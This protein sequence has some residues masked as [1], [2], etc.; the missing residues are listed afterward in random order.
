MIANW[1]LN[2]KIIFRSPGKT[3]FG[4]H[5]GCWVC[6]LSRGRCY[7][8]IFVLVLH[9]AAQMVPTH[10]RNENESKT[11]QNMRRIPHVHGVWIKCG[12]YIPSDPMYMG[13][14]APK[15][16]FFWLILVPSMCEHH[17]GCEVETFILNTPPY[18]VYW[19]LTRLWWYLG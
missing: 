11:A 16:D 19:R 9:L 6:G 1:M 10:V 17:L 4:K 15:F 13:Y 12:V 14:P 2:S 3:I 18:W 5:V 7:L 8:I